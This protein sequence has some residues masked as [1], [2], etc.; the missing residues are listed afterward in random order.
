MPVVLFSGGCD[1]T[2]VLYD[3]AMKVLKSN[4][5]EHIT[6]VSINHDQVPANFQQKTAREK[7]KAEFEKRELTFIRYIE[8]DIKQYG[9]D[10]EPSGIAH[11]VIWLPTATL[12]LHKEDSLYLGYHSGDDYW[13]YR[14]H[15]ELAVTNFCSVLDKTI[16]LVYPLEGYYK[17][18]IIKNL[19]ARGLYDLCWYCEYPTKE[20]KP[21]G[22][23]VPCKA[24]RT[25]LWQLETF[26]KIIDVPSFS[27]VGETVDVIKIAEKASADISGS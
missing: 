21:C 22:T 5:S 24:H 9:G 3:L 14:S 27:P 18:Q 6:A 2:L 20:N 1:S 23:C 19:R 4:F 15:A 16:K 26:D 12:Y 11:P 13:I 17:L 25:A 10:V 7:I 8:V